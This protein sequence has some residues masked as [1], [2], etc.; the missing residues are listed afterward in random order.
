MEEEVAEMK[1]RVFIVMLLVC[2]GELVVLD[3]FT[4]DHETV[5]KLI[6]EYYGIPSEDIMIEYDRFLIFRVGG[7]TYLASPFYSR[8]NNTNVLYYT[9]SSSS[10][11]SSEAKDNTTISISREDYMDMAYLHSLNEV[12]TYNLESF[13]IGLFYLANLLIIFMLVRD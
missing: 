6:M 5:H 11:S 12:I 9:P 3:Q 10:S 4:A 8:G 1:L 13:L 2:M 7:E